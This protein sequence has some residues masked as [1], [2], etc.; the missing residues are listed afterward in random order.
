MTA[1]V[2]TRMALATAGLLVA[3][4]LCLIPL[5]AHAT[6][7]AATQQTRTAH[8]PTVGQPVLP[9]CGT[10][11]GSDDMAPCDGGDHLIYRERYWVDVDQPRVTATHVLMLGDEAYLECAPGYDHDPAA[12]PCWHPATATTPAGIVDGDEDEPLDEPIEWL[13]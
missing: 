5:G 6:P 13:K 10:L 9:R 3:G 12:G 11:D 7:A 8:H 1:V 2:G 4:P